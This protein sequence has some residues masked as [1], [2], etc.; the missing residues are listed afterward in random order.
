MKMTKLNVLRCA[1]KHFDGKAK[2]AIADYNEGLITWAELGKI[3]TDLSE[4][5]TTLI[6]K[7][8]NGPLSTL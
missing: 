1:H 6:S 8:N 3:L 7:I 4:E 2:N 5:K